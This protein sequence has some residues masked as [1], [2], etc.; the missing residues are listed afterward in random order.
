M[1]MLDRQHSKE[2]SDAR[3]TILAGGLALLAMVGC[4]D[5]SVAAGGGGGHGGEGGGAT[6]PLTPEAGFIEV[7]PAEGFG[8]KYASRMFYSFWPAE[9]A[10]ED[11]PLL[12]Y[13][14]GSGAATTS[15]LLPYG[16]A[17]ATLDVLD[18]SDTP[19][20]NPSRTHGSQLAEEKLRAEL[21]ELT[22]DDAYWLQRA[23]PCEDGRLPTR[24]ALNV[25]LDV[26]PRT[27]MFLTNARYD[28]VVYTE[29]LPSFFETD[30]DLDVTL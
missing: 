18:A 10:P 22:S 30:L 28:A 3:R 21:G 26:L 20:P 27:R 25:I 14:N 7:P 24:T 29:A 5:D 19:A 6:E 8:P 13:F 11:A 16:T 4:G 12:V 9:D 2:L 23:V 15:I 17:P 1:T